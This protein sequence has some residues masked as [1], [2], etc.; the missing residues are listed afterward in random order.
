MTKKNCFC[1]NI[2]RDFAKVGCRVLI[3][4]DYK[5]P[6]TDYPLKKAGYAK[7]KRK[8]YNKGI[9]IMEGVKG[10][11][12]FCIS[13]KIP[14]T[15]LEINNETWMVD[16]PMHWE[17]MKLLAENCYGEVL[18][19]GLGLGLITHALIKNP[20]IEKI[21]VVEINKDVIK[22]IQPLI[23]KKVKV[24]QGNI[25]DYADS[26]NHY[27]IVILDLWVRNGGKGNLLPDMYRA[28]AQFAIR[29]PKSKIY[30]WGLRDRI[31][32][33]AVH[34]EPCRMLLEIEKRRLL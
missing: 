25:F 22:L 21:H 5:T 24:T 1:E 12:F 20:Q 30:I 27:D 11:D 31:L 28:L 8:P 15:S 17:G 6:A 26:N 10:Y 33:P 4:N 18:V 2:K 19:G 23:P 3:I 9:Y 7:I 13:K 29:C 16:D 34:K 32:N 14:V